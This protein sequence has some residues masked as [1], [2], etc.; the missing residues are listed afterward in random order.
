MTLAHI[1]ISLS[2][3]LPSDGITRRMKRDQ[4]S[5]VLGVAW[6]LILAVS[7]LAISG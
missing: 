7:M 5:R 3:Q 1:L 6:Y 4:R 2:Q